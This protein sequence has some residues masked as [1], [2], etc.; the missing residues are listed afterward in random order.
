[1]EFMLDT[2]ICIYIIK[3]KPPEV[4]KRFG[5]SIISQVGISSITLSE[6]LYG[7]V[8]SSNPLKNRIALTQFVAPLEIASYDD[9]AAQCYGDI[10][11]G[12]ENRGLPIGALDML[13]AAH[14]L[15]I[16]CTLVT[17]N[18]RAFARIPSLKIDNWIVQ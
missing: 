15:S 13:L 16:G 6:L 12:L 3:R 18:T 11:A 9:E 14:A 10:R 17:N 7:V 2:N 1:M 4:I 8:N 5:K